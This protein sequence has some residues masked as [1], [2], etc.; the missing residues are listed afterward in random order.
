MRLNS[1]LPP[2]TGALLLTLLVVAGCGRDSGEPPD[3][4]QFSTQRQ[5]AGEE[6]LAV[7]VEYGAGRFSVGRAETHTLY[8]VD[9]RYDAEIYRPT[10][11]FADGRLQVGVEGGSGSGRMRGRNLGDGYLRLGLSPDVPTSLDLRFGAAVADI[12]LG[13]LPLSEVSIQ[14][15]ASE[16]RITVSE[17]NPLDAGTV[18][19]EAGAA[20]V[21]VRNLGNLNART[22]NIAGGVGDITLGFSGEARQAMSANISIGMGSLTLEMPR[23]LGVEVRRTGVLSAFDGQ[24]L[25]RRGDSYFSEDWESATR[26]LTVNLNAAVGRVR[27]KWIDDPTQ[28]QS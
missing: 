24:E 27:V 3:W 26:R 19:I 22:I 25:V 8:S 18:T 5:P 17:P 16:T 20:K 10:T 12:E 1:P 28:P 4:R 6:Q 15:G 23:G 2:T 14:T 21:Q 13:G 7:E 11:H 9:M